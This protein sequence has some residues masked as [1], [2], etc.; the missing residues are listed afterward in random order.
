[1]GTKGSRHWLLAR[2][3]AGAAV[4]TALA[5]AAQLASAD[6]AGESFWTP[7]SFGSLAATPSQPGFSLSSGYYHTSTTAGSEVARA[8]L[9][10][11]GRLS[12]AVEESVSAISISPED[13]ATVTPGYTFATPV[14]GGQAA[15]ALT[16][17]YG[18]KRTTDDVTISGERLAGSSALVRSRFE[19]ISDTITGFGDLSPQASLRWNSGVHNV[20]TYMTG[21]IPVGAYDRARLSNIGIGHG[22]LDGGAGYTYFNEQTGYEFSAVAG[23][24]YNFI[25][26]HTQYQNGVDVHVDWGASRFL[27][28][29]LQIGL[30]G[31][32]YNQ[33]NCD[34]GSGDRVGCFQSRVASV[35][36]QF[37]YTIAMGALDG[38]VN[39][40]AYKEFAAANRPE[41]WNL[42]L[43]YTLAPAEQAP[44]RS[45]APPRRMYMK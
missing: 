13:L 20:M 14:L 21:N 23:L 5:V 10:R 12:G 27:T 34:G 39:L 40:K 33:A 8:R 16:A 42:W 45:T 43:A 3:L 35:G 44:A 32:L 22:A 29:Q 31:Y 37:G 28:K 15:V 4:T 38:N 19:S 41:G 36:A 26:P 11:I 17:T 6:E 24:T 1:M 30:V 7:G 9:I 25:N 2:G 18:R